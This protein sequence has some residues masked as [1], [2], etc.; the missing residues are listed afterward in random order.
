M[1]QRFVTGS[2]TST[3]ADGHHIGSFRT[4]RKVYLLVMPGIIIRSVG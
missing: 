2:S 3:D 4:I 1:I